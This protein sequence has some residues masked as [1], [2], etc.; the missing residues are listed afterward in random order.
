[1]KLLC[2]VHLRWFDESTL[3]ED[4]QRKL[5]E[6]ALNALGITSDAAR[7]LFHVLLASRASDVSLTA[8]QLRDAV[9]SLRRGRG[10]ENP[11]EGLTMRNLHVWLQYFRSIRLVEKLGNR[12]HFRGNRKPSRA[13]AEGTRQLVEGSMGYVERVLERLELSYGVE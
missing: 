8:R 10:M 6:L 12:Y 11:E 1:M 7:D 13:F 4:D 3:T 9:V 2:D 5:L